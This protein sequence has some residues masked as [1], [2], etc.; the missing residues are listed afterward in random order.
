[1]GLSDSVIHL[2]HFLDPSYFAPNL[3]T[4]PWFSMSVSHRLVTYLH[5]VIFAVLRELNIQMGEVEVDSIPFGDF[6]IPRLFDFIGI[7]LRIVRGQDLPIHS[8]PSINT[9]QNGKQDNTPGRKSTKMWVTQQPPLTLDTGRSKG[10]GE[11]SQPITER[12]LD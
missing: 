10:E 2:W 3:T 5:G 9:C 7:G 6:Y 1:M 11:D 8:R 4:Q 12:I